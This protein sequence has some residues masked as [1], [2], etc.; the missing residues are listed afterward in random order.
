MTSPNLL[1]ELP[2]LIAARI[3]AVMPELA[4]CKG[5]VGRADVE[6]LK[7]IG[8][9]SPA[10]LI[11]RVRTGQD[12]TLAGPHV[13]YRVEMAAFVVCKDGL[14]LPRH[15]MAGRIAQVL[16]CLI[17][18]NHWGQPDDLDGAEAVQ[19]LPLASKAADEAG[20]SIIAVTWQHLCALSNL[21]PDEPIEP[22][23]YLGLV[24]QIGAAH[25]DAYD[26]I[27]GEP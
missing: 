2:D 22:Q 4:T 26:E 3:R 7:R 16:L 14:G 18:N 8:V 24:P 23:V 15:E 10:V 21:P 5:L 1:A 25:V 19:E 27:G 9:A 13:T 6:M 12:K 20:L 17:P 11:S